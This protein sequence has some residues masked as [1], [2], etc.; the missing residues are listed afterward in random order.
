MI[1]YAH[2]GASGY[3]PENTMLAFQEGVKMGATGLETDV[4]MTKDGVLILIHDETLNRTTNGKGFVKDYTYQEIAELDAGSWYKR[5]FRGEKIPTLRELLEF[6]KDK[7]II[8]NLELKN[9]L[10]PY[11]GME[12]L[13]L[14]LIK[15]YKVEKKIIISSFNHYSIVKVKKL[16]N[17]IKTAILYTEGLFHPERYA[18]YVGANAIHPYYLAINKEIVNEVKK[19]K[20]L[21]NPYTVNKEEDMLNLIKMEVDGIITNYPDKLHKLLSTYNHK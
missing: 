14:Q 16:N 4:Q 2:R 3:F 6:V 15:E 19:E 10:I 8:L 20:I 13:V 9:T 21:I 1:N 18:K 12:E 5:S 11:H 17:K 7:N